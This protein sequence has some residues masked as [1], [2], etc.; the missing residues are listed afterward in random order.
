MRF[1]LKAMEALKIDNVFDLIE[2][3]KKFNLKVDIDISQDLKTNKEKVYYLLNEEYYK[4]R[5]NKFEF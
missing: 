5:D 4:L 3:A 2:F 1:K